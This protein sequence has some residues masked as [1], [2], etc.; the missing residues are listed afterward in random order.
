MLPFL[1]QLHY[2]IIPEVFRYCGVMSVGLTIPV[3][4]EIDNDIF[5][6]Q[7]SY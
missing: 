6:L 5:V 7:F 2:Y 1:D 3:Y 4:S